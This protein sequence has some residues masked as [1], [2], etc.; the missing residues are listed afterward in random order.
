M[1]RM[2]PP[3]LKWA[4]Q[5]RPRANTTTSI[6]SILYEP[7]RIT[8]LRRI[9][10]SLCLVQTFKFRRTRPLGSVCIFSRLF[11]LA[12][13]HVQATSLHRGESFE[14]SVHFLIVNRFHVRPRIVSPTILSKPNYNWRLKPDKEIVMNRAL[15]QWRICAEASAFGTPRNSFLWQLIINL[16]FAKLRRA[17]R[18]R[19]VERTV[20][21]ARVSEIG[22]HPKSEIT[23]I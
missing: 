19:G 21:P 3:I 6:N 5:N 17:V 4:N 7:T 10:G 22:G 1:T 20:W 8:L 2:F 13:I 11:K 12:H 9:F 23:K 14:S 16:K 18:C 15:I